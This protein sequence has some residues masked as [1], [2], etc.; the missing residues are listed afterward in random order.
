LLD[1]GVA[2]VTL[3]DLQGIANREV[4]LKTFEAILNKRG[5]RHLDTLGYHPH[6]VVGEEAVANSK[7][8]Y[9]TGIKRFDSSLGGT[10]G[11][12]TGA[13]GN[14]PTEMLVRLFNK[15]GIATGLNEQKIFSLAEMV[16]REL[17]SNIPLNKD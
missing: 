15:L 17:Y 12:V 8:A 11:C 14:Q 16:R 1:L 7:I 10:G 9:D 5:G 4:T 13:P 6:H 2:T 3:S